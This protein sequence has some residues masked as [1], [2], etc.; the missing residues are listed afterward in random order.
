[1][2]G[3]KNISSGFQIT[4]MPLSKSKNK[5]IQEVLLYKMR[6][7]NLI[8]DRVVCYLLCNVYR[9][10]RVD[11]E[12]ATIYNTIFSEHEMALH[13]HLAAKEAFKDIDSVKHW[14]YQHRILS[15]TKSGEQFITSCI[16][17]FRVN[18]SV[19]ND[20]DTLLVMCNE[21]KT[22]FL[23]ECLEC[24]AI[25]PTDIANIADRTIRILK[26][27]GVMA[28]T[29]GG[30]L[31]HLYNY[32]GKF[33]ANHLN[34]KNLDLISAIQRGWIIE[35]ESCLQLNGRFSVYEY[36]R[37]S[38]RFVVFI[39]TMISDVNNAQQKN[40]EHQ[41]ATKKED[42]RQS[43]IERVKTL[44]KKAELDPISRVHVE[45]VLRRTLVHCGNRYPDNML[46]SKLIDTLH[47]QI[48]H[49]CGNNPR[50]P[51]IMLLHDLLWN[52]N[53]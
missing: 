42:A 3:Y 35:S 48:R 4:K 20:D 37:E 39:P 13:S 22:D 2:F 5:S 51:Y 49:N 52:D 50:M 36:Q 1:M 53:N 43:L 7:S 32:G 47:E 6:N 12:T 38:A 30:Y 8:W 29:E 26:E 25:E 46:E 18:R 40:P 21:T 27:R 17:V 15:K 45:A 10:G 23:L 14:M 24:V 9:D 41:P 44:C 16:S 28:R 19:Y 33:P 11:A 31:F 34:T